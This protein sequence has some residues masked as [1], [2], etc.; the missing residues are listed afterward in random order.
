MFIFGGTNDSWAGSPIGEIMYEDFKKSDL[1][2]VLPAFSYLLGRT[3]E[4][5]ENTR[6]IVIINTE[7][8]AEIANGQKSICEHYG[9]EYVAAADGCAVG[10]DIS[11]KTMTK[12]IDTVREKNLKYAYYVEM[13]N[14]E[15][16][17]SLSAQ[18]GVKLLELHSAHNVTLDDFENGVTYV[19]IMERNYMALKEG[20]G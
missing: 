2:N 9:I 8:K 18:T 11:L 12:L 4:V 14:K 3:K 1:Y 7:L 5:L 10:T 20:I 19:D 15:I 17:N 16:A 13:S 6:V